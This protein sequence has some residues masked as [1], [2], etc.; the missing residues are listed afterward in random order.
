MPRFKTYTGYELDHK[1]YDRAFNDNIK[2]KIQNIN[3]LENI[4]ISI[5]EEKFEYEVPVTIDL[6]KVVAALAT[7]R[8]SIDTLGQYTCVV[9]EG[10]TSLIL[11]EEYNQFIKDL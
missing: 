2:E 4:Q 8:S 10:N 11:K 6:D 5:D 3:D 1:S 7:Y 9:F